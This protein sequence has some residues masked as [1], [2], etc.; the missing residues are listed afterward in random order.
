MGSV[1]LTI[2]DEWKSSFIG[3]T[4]NFELS[5]DRYETLASLAYFEEQLST[6]PDKTQIDIQYFRMP[7]GRVG[8][9]S[10][11]YRI[12]TQELKDTNI[13]DDLLT[14]G[15]ANNSEE[16]LALFLRCFES[17]AGRMSW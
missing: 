14:H 2:M 10:Y 16:D 1:H 3:T 11:S 13:L 5:Y 9:N 7:V 4:A 17:I 8:W 6:Y 15:F 12:L